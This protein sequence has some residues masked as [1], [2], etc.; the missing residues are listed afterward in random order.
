MCPPDPPGPPYLG[1]LGWKMTMQRKGLELTAW[2]VT[3]PRSQVEAPN[4]VTPQRSRPPYDDRGGNVH[5][6]PKCRMS[7]PS[8]R[9][10]RL[11]T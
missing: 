4:P 11:I 9:V 1:N 6:R 8:K 2:R 7:E 10:C 3:L 5:V